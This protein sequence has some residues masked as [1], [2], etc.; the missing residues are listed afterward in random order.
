VSMQLGAEKV[1]RRMGVVRSAVEVQ[2]K[3]AVSLRTRGSVPA[4]VLG[5]TDQA[6]AL[7]AG[8]QHDA[9]AQ[10]SGREFT[11]FPKPRADLRGHWT[12]I[13]T[14]R[15]AERAKC[16]EKDRLPTHRITM[17]AVVGGRNQSTSCLTA[18]ARL[19]ALLVDDLRI[20]F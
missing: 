4:S 19:Q 1:S 20:Q 15:T 7:R 3:L 16:Q 9:R 6:V 13:A 8:V 18:V 14:A 5:L 17:H 11:E 12:R 10:F 2:R